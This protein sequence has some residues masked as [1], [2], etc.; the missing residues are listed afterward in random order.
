[1]KIRETFK[2]VWKSSSASNGGYS[3]KLHYV[4]V[5]TVSQYYPVIVDS[6]KQQW[7]TPDL[8]QSQNIC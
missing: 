7:A 1:M 2:N 3:I 4:N 8:Y 5:P 6:I